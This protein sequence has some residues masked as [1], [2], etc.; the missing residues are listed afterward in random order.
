L[1]A[2]SLVLGFDRRKNF[3]TETAPAAVSD[4]SNLL[5]LKLSENRRIFPKY[6]DWILVSSQACKGGLGLLGSECMAGNRCPVKGYSQYQLQSQGKDA[7][8]CLA[9][10]A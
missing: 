5:S 8:G 1:T 4:T 6:I 10:A 3:E 9:G 2:G 7:K